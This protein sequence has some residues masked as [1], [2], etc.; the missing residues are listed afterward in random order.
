MTACSGSTCFHARSR[1]SGVNVRMSRITAKDS[2]YGPAV[3]RASQPPQPQNPTPHHLLRMLVAGR[4]SQNTTYWKCASAVLACF[5]TQGNKLRAP[6]PDQTVSRGVPNIELIGCQSV[7][8][9]LSFLGL[10]TVAR[11]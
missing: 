11:A 10:R 9:W 8:R 6:S 4:E 7:R 3:G 5:R 1:V 2:V